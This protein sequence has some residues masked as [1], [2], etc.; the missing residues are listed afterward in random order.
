MKHIDLRN[1]KS[2]MKHSLNM[3]YSRWDATKER[4]V[5]TNRLIPTEAQREKKAKNQNETTHTNMK[6][7]SLS[8][9]WDIILDKLTDEIEFL[10]VEWEKDQRKYIWQKKAQ[11]LF[12]N[13][14][15][16]EKSSSKDKQS[17]WYSIKTSTRKPYQWR[18]IKLLKIHDKKKTLKA[19]RRKKSHVE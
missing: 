13:L 19:N 4:S 14:N 1:A 12:E 17:Q 18:S 15:P 2:E 5:S 11:D 16:T 10:G 6:K 8:D 9:L 3:S 7:Q